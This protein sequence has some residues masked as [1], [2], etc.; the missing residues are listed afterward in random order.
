MLLALE[1]GRPTILCSGHSGENVL[2]K[3]I[4]HFEVV[5]KLGEGG[6]GVVYKARDSHL[7][8]FVAL[9]V[10]PPDK[11]ADPERRRR[12][13]QE[14]KAASALQHPNIV[15]VYDIA[16]TDGVHFIAME[17][18]DGRT[19]D[20][21]IGRK[22]MRLND[23]LKCAVQI[24]DALARAHA[25]GIVHRDLKP[26]NIMVDAHGLVKVLDF[27]LAKLIERSE[28]GESAPTETVRADEAPRTGEGT[29]V[30]TVAYMSPEQ[31]EGLPVDARSDIFSFGA[32]LYE[33]ATGRRAFAGSTRLSTL[34][35]IL[36]K[37]PAPLTCANLPHDLERIVLRCL[38]KDPD[39]RFHHMVDLRVA[40]E[41]LKEESDSGGL[42]A[43][44]PPRAGRRAAWIAALAGLTLAAALAV[45]ATVLWRKPAQSPPPVPTR[46]TADSGLTMEPAL[47]PDGRLVAYASDRAGAGNL[48]IWVQSVAGGESNRLT[49]DPADEREP[50]FSPDGGRIAFR[51]EKDGG[52]IWV[53]PAFGGQPRL[54]AP[55]GRRPRFSPDGKWLAYYVGAIVNG[56]GLNSTLQI[57]P[58]TGGTPRPIETGLGATAHPVWTPD[59]NHLLCYGQQLERT[60]TPR[61]DWWVVPRDGGTAVR[62]GAF[63]VLRKAGLTVEGDDVPAIAPGDWFG[64]QVV[65][66]GQFRGNRNLWQLPM[67]PVTGQVAGR[68][69]R[70][71]FGAGTEVQPAAASPA[72]VAFSSLLTYLNVWSL[73]VD[74]DQARVLKPEP[75]RLTASAYD[76]Q[77]SLSADGRRLVFVSTRA[78]NRDIWWKDLATG[79]ESAL[80]LTPAEEFNPK[81]S[82][83]G[84]QVLYQ[85][86]EEN[87]WN[88]YRARLGPDGQP[89]A[90]E[91]ICAGCRRLWD[92][93][94][95]NRKILF[96][97]AASSVL[98]IGLLELGSGRKTELLRPPSYGL[99]RV[100]FSPDDRWIS[101][102]A[103]T[104]PGRTRVSVV[105]FRPGAALPESQWI[106]VTDDVSIHDKAVWAPGGNLLYFTSD[107]DGFRCIYAQRLDAA[108]KRP[109]GPQLDVYHSHGARR[110]ILN[111]DIIP[112]ELAVSRD[113]LVFHLAEITGNVWLADL[114]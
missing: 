62:T 14:A 11:L 40:L 88:L 92:L 96:A 33:M 7:D 89:G 72:R 26:S 94:S 60:T 113:R 27:G 69:A 37:E 39:R 50:A 30:G 102:T 34:A 36:H 79:K 29:I 108:T 31:A 82:S 59:G 1:I 67:S 47:S 6:M 98:S 81:I 42:P 112:L 103:V 91:K 66:S 73:A 106:A 16:E 20:E 51:S 87:S 54:V 46:L 19:L 52:G 86:I 53:V 95:D 4:A 43:P 99:Y 78:G 93:S 71:T 10:L 63:D 45:I 24:A 111:A 48:D 55:E 83:D 41:E 17:Y 110:S 76:A 35:A 12:F 85:V 9:K 56:G 109:V 61:F 49:S 101:F 44:A 90:P 2:G 13:V 57:V 25:A 23:L 15:H 77:C 65:F 21:L 5:G 74:A 84:S 58:S 80:T 70:L 64:D 32:V 3:T 68:P 107:R 104:G 100:R 105:P 18:I 38:R 28:S 114:K 8:R 75:E 97:Y 22:P